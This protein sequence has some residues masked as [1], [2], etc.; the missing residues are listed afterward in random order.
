MKK[1]I[2]NS[3]LLLSALVPVASSAADAPSATAAE[4]AAAETIP[5]Y[6]A[7]TISGDWGGARSRLFRAGVATEFV[8]KIDA[9]SNIHGGIR[10]GR[11]VMGNL[12]GK[13]RF[14]L[15]KLAG[16]SDTTALLHVHG[17]Q[18][19]KVN[20]RHVGSALGVSNIEVATNTTKVFQGWIQKNVGDFSVLAGLYPIDTE[21]QTVDAAGVFI[22]PPYGA[23]GELALTRGPSIFNT[24]SFGTRI[25]WTAPER[26]IYAQFAL[27]DG[28]PG[29]PA[30]PNGTHIRFAK[31]DGS[32]TIAELGWTPGGQD[33]AAKYAGGLW[34]YSTRADHLVDIDASGNPHRSPSWGGY[35][36]A[37]RPLF[38]L[39]DDPARR[40]STFFRY[41]LT[42]GRS[43]PLRDT[44]NLGL[45]FKAPLAGREND[46]FGVALTRGR[47]GSVWRTAQGIAGILPA[48][49]EYA[50]E[51]TYR[52]Q[53]AR[54]CHVQPVWQHLRHPGG[55]KATRDADVVGARVEL[56]F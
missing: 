21:F 35:L 4:P 9:L 19:G 33:A 39:N 26:P 5:D 22:Q 32:F 56:A 8:W 51:I 16:W 48:D 18:G 11:S 27:L 55:D 40:V 38:R 43:T 1:Q 6:A 17:H 15:D 53:L 20:T 42:D 30:N 54:A 3:L 34:R 23:T 44:F 13:F 49:T 31:G 24:S 37:E 25:R 45:N 50:T 28:M 36:L 41:S 14:D 29:D 2:A 46:T 7:E 10:H 52:A 12:E 47:F